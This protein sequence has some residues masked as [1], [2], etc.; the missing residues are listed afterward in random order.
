VRE[1]FNTR[2]VALAFATGER[3]QQASALAILWP[4]RTDFARAASF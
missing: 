4:S 3:L 2:D 1:T